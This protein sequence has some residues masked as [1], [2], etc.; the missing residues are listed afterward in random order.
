M[1]IV[2]VP[3]PN[4]ARIR[5]VTAANDAFS[6]LIRLSED[7]G[8]VSHAEAVMSDG[9]IIAARIGDGVKR[10]ANDY[11]KTSTFQIF[12]DLEMPAAQYNEW[13]ASMEYRLGWK[14]DLP[15]VFGFVF[16]NR[17]MHDPRQLICSALQVDTLRHCLWFPRPLAQYYHSITPVMLLLMLQADPR[18]VFPSM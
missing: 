7:G 4:T 16:Y 9:S 8:S 15:A 18:S 1:L 6:K 10:Y 11:D 12:C 5:F 14:Y 3:P 13:V 17:R 2:P